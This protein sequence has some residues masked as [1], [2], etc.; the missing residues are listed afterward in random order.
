[1]N[2]FHIHIG[3]IT[4]L[5]APFN[6]VHGHMSASL[7][8]SSDKARSDIG[9]SGSLPSVNDAVMSWLRLKITFGCFS[10]FAPLS[11]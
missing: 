10:L 3:Y 1:V 6:D 5:L 9:N 2:A 8:C 7:H 11:I 4:S